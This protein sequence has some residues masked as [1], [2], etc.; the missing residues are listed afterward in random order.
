M[1]FE[2]VLLEGVLDLLARLLQITLSL[3]GLAFGA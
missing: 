3:I 2:S 1:A